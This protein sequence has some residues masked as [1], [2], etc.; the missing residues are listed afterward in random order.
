MSLKHAHLNACVDA[1]VDVVVNG[2]SPVNDVL[3]SLGSV[4]AMDYCF[5]H[6]NDADDPDGFD[7]VEPP[8]KGYYFDLAVAIDCAHFVPIELVLEPLSVISLT[9]NYSMT[10]IRG[11]FVQN[12]DSDMNLSCALGD[13]AHRWPI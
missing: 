8:I 5:H 4:H 2:S 1:D 7:V 3:L 12:L 11:H 6:S 10:T 13:C 9:P